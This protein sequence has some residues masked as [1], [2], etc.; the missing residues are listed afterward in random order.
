MNAFTMT[1][2]TTGVVVT[3][4]QA[5]ASR[6]VVELMDIDCAPP[7]LVGWKIFKTESDAKE[8]AD[9]CLQG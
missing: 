5:D 2:K 1:N 9:K 7:E 6:W 3:I 4:V 8:Y